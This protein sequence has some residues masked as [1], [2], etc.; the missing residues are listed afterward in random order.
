MARD[1]NRPHPSALARY[2]VP[3]ELISALFRADDAERDRLLAPMPA[4]GRARI[5]AYCADHAPARGARPEGRAVLRRG[6][7]R[8]GR[9]RNGRRRSVRALAGARTGADPA[10]G[11]LIDLRVPTRPVEAVGLMNARACP[12]SQPPAHPPVIGP[13]RPGRRFRRS[14]HDAL[15][16]ARPR[17]DG[18]GGPRDR[19]GG[20][21]GAV[22]L[23][24]ARGRRGDRARGRAAAVRASTPIPG[25]IAGP[26]IAAGAGAARADPTVAGPA[27]AATTAATVA[28]TV[29]A[30]PTAAGDPHRRP[31]NRS[32]R[33]ELGP[34]RAS[35]SAAGRCWT[36]ARPP[37]CPP[38]TD[39][40]IFTTA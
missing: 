35:G 31:S 16:D 9:G 15:Q 11:R 17:R 10:P 3:I 34:P 8:P 37:T 39:K 36:S 30:G 22:R 27:T 23:R 13:V 14:C 7:A 21:R 5:A 32:P 29:R 12:G 28:T 2:P 1:G 6:H 26:T 4:Y 19:H 24:P 20:E 33:L 25:A 40:A 18:R 38:G